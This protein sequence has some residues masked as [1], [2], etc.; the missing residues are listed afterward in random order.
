MLKMIKTYG[1]LLFVV[2]GLFVSCRGKIYD[3]GNNS[4]VVP[5]G[6]NYSYYNYGTGTSPTTGAMVVNVHSNSTSTIS[7]YYT[8]QIFGLGTYVIQ[9]GYNQLFMSNIW[10]NSYSFSIEKVCTA[11]NSNGCFPRLLTGQA[12]I[13]TET[14]TVVDVWF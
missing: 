5:V 10:A 2:I 11:N 1:T 8:V 3:P 13:N 9:S 14:T 4:N 6:I 12:L 7:E